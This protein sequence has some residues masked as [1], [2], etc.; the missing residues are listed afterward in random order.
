MHILILGGSGM[1]GHSVADVLSEDGAHQVTVTYRN[2]PEALR[3]N[4]K[5]KQI[6]GVD[7][8]KPGAPEHIIAFTKPDLVVNCV[9]IIKQ[10]DEVAN[11]PQTIYINALLP[12]LLSQACAAHG[13]RLVHPST[14]CVFDGVKGGY[15]EDSH[16]NATDLY[17]KSKHLGEVTGA[18]H[19]LTLRTSIIGHEIG[20]SVSLVDWFLTQSGKVRGFRKAIYTG[21][22][23]V[24]LA[25]IVRNIVI[26]NPGLSGLFQVASAPINKYDLLCL[27]RERYGHDI[28]I[29]PY[30]D[31]V[32]DR[33]LNADAFKAATGYV[34]PEWPEL[35][36]RMYQASPYSQLIH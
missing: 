21:L 6:E 32:I 29:E 20:R 24:E 9:G 3:G 36:D 27:V 15:R 10:L 31:F 7:L 12:H 19:A 11:V 18:S 35:V 1:L 4:K 22:P 17:G 26:P 16:P 2:T 13:A 25:N 30:D 8:I 23:T 5:Y 14:D 33:S 28:E 34:A